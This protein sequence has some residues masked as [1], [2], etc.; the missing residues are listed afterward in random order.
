M[1]TPLPESAG[2]AESLA[3][4]HLAAESAATI[5][6]AVAAELAAA[7]ASARHPLH[8]L[9]VATVDATGAPHARTVVLR[10]FDATD[11]EVWFHTDIRSPKAEQIGVDGRVALHWYDP[12]RRL[13]I[14]IAA[15]A[16]IHHGDALA[17]AAWRTS[18]P[19]SR[20]CYTT[21]E[22]PGTILETVP[23]APP[24]PATDD[25]RGLAAFAVICCRFECVELLSLHASGHERI[26]LRLTGT[27]P[28]REI[29]AP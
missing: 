5:W 9:T 3:G 29:L 12:A 27:E 25:D 15:T 10:G 7:A 6:Q 4:L 22:S 23:P 14:R 13:Q 26:R 19:M 18:Q 24:P 20:A 11:R 16:T 2:H 8:L 1:M 17:Q 21:G 28:I